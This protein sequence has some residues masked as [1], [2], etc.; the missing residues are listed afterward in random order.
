MTRTPEASV[1][2]HPSCCQLRIWGV[3]VLLP[4]C[5]FIDK[6]MAARERRLLLET[7]RLSQTDR[8]GS[9]PR[10]PGP[11]CERTVPAANYNTPPWKGHCLGWGSL[12]SSFPIK[13][14]K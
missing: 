12:C 1:A 7:R 3:Y 9:K 5:H 11:Q 8:T 6:A 2:L 10:P 14:G 13:T 4:L